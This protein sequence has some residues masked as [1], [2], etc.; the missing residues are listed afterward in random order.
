MTETVLQIGTRAFSLGDVLLGCAVLAVLLLLG[1]VFALWRGAVARAAAE[2]AAAERAHEMEAQ[3]Q[4]I[5]GT[6]GEMTGRMQTIAEVFGT[7][8]SDLASALSQRLDTLSHKVGQSMTETTRQTQ[9]SLSRVHERLAVIDRA[10]ANIHELSS[11]VV[12][13]QQILAN[14]Q[15]RG[16][17]GQGRMEAI[18]QDGLAPGAYEFQATLTNRSRP[19]CLVF[20]PNDVPP[21]VIDAKFP[22]EAWTALREAETPEATKAGAQRFRQDIQ[23]H[24][25]D[26]AERYL[27]PG[28]TQETAF[29]FV[30]S[31]SI[32]AD[33]HEH[34]D[35]L[36]QKAHRARVV[37]VSPSLLM[38]SIQVIQAVLKDARM[39]EQ[40]HVIQTEV[41]K[42]MEDMGRL[43]DRVR[44]LRDHF[45]Q[46]AKD[47]DQILIST[48]KVMKRGNRIEALDFDEESEPAADRQLLAGE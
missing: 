42:L 36:V 13:L 1:L 4:A 38:L 17:F 48:D 29:M 23:K 34:F 32:F 10:Q 9:E 46:T 41:A 24:I 43:D 21:L 28:E 12:Q 26:I 45:G 14:K 6:Q 2:A 47:I 7:R 5:L 20:M 3:I 40:A 15:S 18:I 27:I 37:I 16:A 33:I 31:E 11:H 19:D 30:P 44:K 8:Q 35:D 39:R 25:G 22:L